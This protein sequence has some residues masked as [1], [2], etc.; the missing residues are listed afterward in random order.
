MNRHLHINRPALFVSIELVLF[1]PVDLVLHLECIL[2]PIY[3]RQL[4]T[5]NITIITAIN[6][7]CWTDCDHIGRKIKTHMWLDMEQQGL[8]DC[9]QRFRGVI[10]YY[11]IWIVCN[12][13]FDNHFNRSEYRH[14]YWLYY[15]GGW[16]WVIVNTILALIRCE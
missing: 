14:Y 9:K 15:S 5:L 4:V 11:C 16:R 8:V 13:I 2:R 6:D 7:M 3:N 12:Q 10:L 1:S